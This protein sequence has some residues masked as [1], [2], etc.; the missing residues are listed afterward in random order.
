MTIVC[1]LRVTTAK[2]FISL[3]AS[4]RHSRRRG[5]PSSLSPL[6]HSLTNDERSGTYGY[7]PSTCQI[8]IITESHRVLQT[9]NR[10]FSKIMF[11]WVPMSL[12]YIHPIYLTRRIIDPVLQ[13]P[14]AHVR[15]D[16]DPRLQ[17]PWS[18]E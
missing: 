13:H 2:D 11:F 12:L 10:V 18:H 8:T 3:C 6:L 15:R 1:L 4:S 16:P 5:I 17:N 9:Q 14:A 7:A